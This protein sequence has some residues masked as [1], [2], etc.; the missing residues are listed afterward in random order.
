M[1]VFSHPYVPHG[2]VCKKGIGLY[3]VKKSL[4]FKAYFPHEPTIYLCP[5]LDESS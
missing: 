4:H 2:A 5:E 3:Q 1:F